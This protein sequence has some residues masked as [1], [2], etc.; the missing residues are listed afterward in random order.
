MGI[1]MQGVNKPHRRE[2][3]TVNAPIPD[4]TEA[5][6]DRL[7][8]R[9]WRPEHDDDDSSCWY[10]TRARGA[11]VGEPIRERAKITVGGTTL[12]AARL[13]YAVWNGVDPG[14]MTVEHLCARGAYGCC[15]PHH[16]VL[17]GR[18]E[19]TLA[20]TS[21]SPSAI[22]ARTTECRRCGGPLTERPAGGRRCRAC[23]N[24][25]MRA[26]R[27]GQR[28][29]RLPYAERRPDLARED[30]CVRG[31]DLADGS[32]NVRMVHRP[33]GRVQK[34][35]RACQTLRTRTAK[36]LVSA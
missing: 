6:M 26:F 32:P 34:A 9:M 33:D 19:N 10:L 29:T 23:W 25:Y 20:T 24:T 18:G 30:L 35:C 5:E 4:L 31:H 22:N 17:L 14:E 13:V 11:H 28:R 15:S 16:L 36:A 8:A 3:S 21:R 12:L 1:S 7:V 2:A 27:Q